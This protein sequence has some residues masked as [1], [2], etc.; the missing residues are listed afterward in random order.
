MFSALYNLLKENGKNGKNGENK[1]NGDEHPLE[2]YIMA[3]EEHLDNDSILRSIGERIGIYVPDEEEASTYL[4]SAL[5]KYL[6]NENNYK[7]TKYKM[8]LTPDEYAKLTDTENLS[9]D[10]FYPLYSNRLFN[11]E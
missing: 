7:N 6:Q 3:V 10:K 11:L 9:R 4:Y 1:K 5:Y 8:D 2:K